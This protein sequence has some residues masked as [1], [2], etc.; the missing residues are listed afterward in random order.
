VVAAGCSGGRT[1]ETIRL[2]TLYVLFFIHLSSRRV[3]LAGVTANP[4]AAWV[5]QQ[6]RN[7]AMDLNDQG[8]AVRI[9]LRDH[10]AKFTR[11][12]DDVFGS[13]GGAAAAGDGAGQAPTSSPSTP[14]VRS[15]PTAQH[16][17]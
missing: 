3:V 1:H 17:H 14:P 9:V 16:R 7:V 2:K 5:T 11:S 8:L 15:A 6:G 10:D 12:F 4:D 13:Q